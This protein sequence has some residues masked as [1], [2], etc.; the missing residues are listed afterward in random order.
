MKDALL[1]AL[2]NREATVNKDL[3]ANDAIL[4]SNSS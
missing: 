4:T 3:G 1:V 2:K